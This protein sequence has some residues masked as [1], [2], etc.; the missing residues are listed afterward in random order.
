MSDPA[1]T[2]DDTVAP[3]RWLSWDIRSNVQALRALLHGR[4]ARRRA[5]AR[6]IG[7]LAFAL[8]VMGVALIALVFLDGPVGAYRK[9][10]PADLRALARAL[11]DIGESVWYLIPTGA[12]LL[13]GLVL[14]WRAM[15]R[16]R[17]WLMA[18]WYALAGY[19]FVTIA[20]S[21]LIATL[22]KRVI[23]R[24]RPKHF[25]EH[26][27]L[28]F[29]PFAT[30]A[31]FAS[32]PSG[33]ATTVGALTAIV[34]LLFPRLRLV[35]FVLAILLASTRILVGAHY[36]SDVIAGLGFGL[37]FGYFIALMFAA[38]GLVFTAGASGL[39]A[40]NRP[41]ARFIGETPLR[42][43]SGVPFLQRRSA[44]SG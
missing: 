21:G 10:W 27:V 14:D 24:A 33:H 28:A 38:R 12:F 26:G 8:C 11:T 3:A 31:S 30:S 18:N 15:G 13:F 44:K 23:G 29:D 43:L 32:F 36:P 41:F 25:E 4:K 5:P 17:R 35:A 9:L 7:G 6:R 37:W 42:F 19:S 2:H 1:D 40:V 34:C 16:R 39:P 22:L 20:G